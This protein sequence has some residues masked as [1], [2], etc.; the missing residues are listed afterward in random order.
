M[1]IIMIYKMRS[2]NL[3]NKKGEKMYMFCKL[4]ELIKQVI[5]TDY[6]ILK[7]IITNKLVK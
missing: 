3:Q 4:N 5:G 7:L 1:V 2:F 6:I